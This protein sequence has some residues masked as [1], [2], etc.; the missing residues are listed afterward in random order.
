[1]QSNKFL[2]IARNIAERDKALFDTLMEF[3]KTK[4]IRT[5]TRLNFTIDKSLAS[6][7]KNFCREKGFNM[8]AK[9]EQAIG[10]LIEKG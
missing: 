5:K 6:R 8:S 10:N 1:M 2:K 4:K 7:F 3:E 9:I